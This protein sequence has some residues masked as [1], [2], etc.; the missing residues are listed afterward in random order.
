MTKKDKA[1]KNVAAGTWK[2]RLSDCF[3]VE[4]R[5]FAGAAAEEN[6]A[7]DLLA[8]L[9]KDGVAWSDVRKAI[10]GFLAAQTF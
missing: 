10:R 8:E 6:E 3:G 5:R 9:R 2:E 7:F 4:D 1:R